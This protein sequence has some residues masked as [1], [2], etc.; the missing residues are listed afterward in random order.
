[1]D[2]ESFVSQTLKQL[3]AGVAKAAKGNPGIKISPMVDMSRIEGGLLVDAG[4]GSM[5]NSVEFDLSV[6]V[7]S[8]VEGGAEA[9]VELLSIVDERAASDYWNL[10]LYHEMIGNFLPLP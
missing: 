2:I 9:K 1:M 7:R 10:N 5:I 3:G 8:R 6:I 4:T